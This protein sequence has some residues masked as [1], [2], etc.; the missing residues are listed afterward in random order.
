M[1]LCTLVEQLPNDLDM[2]ENVRKLKLL[3][4][5]SVRLN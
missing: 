2:L 5:F 4:E 1:F 3:N